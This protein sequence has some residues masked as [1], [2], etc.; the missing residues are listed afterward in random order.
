MAT[1]GLAQAPLQWLRR[2]RTIFYRW[3]HFLLPGAVLLGVL[4]A[5][6]SGWWW[7]ETAQNKAFDAFQRLRPRPYEDTAV[8]VVDIDDES[9]RRLGQFPWPRTEL[10][11]LLKRLTDLGAAAV[12]FDIVF[13]EPDRTSPARV[14]RFLP[15]TPDLDSVKE[16]LASL[17]DHDVA[18]SRQLSR[19]PAVMGFALSTE[20]NEIYPE[21]KSVYSYGG[22]GPLAYL[23]DFSGAV[24]NLPVLEKA[25]SGVG[26]FSFVP[27]SDGV[28]R[29]APLILRRGKHLYPGL[30][31]EALRV[32][33]GSAGYAVKSAGASGEASFGAHTGIAKIKIGRFV[34]PTDGE[35]RV[36]VHFPSVEDAQKRVI[37]AWK[38]F[39]KGFTRKEAE[40]RIFFVG[41]SA[42]GLKDLRVTPLNPAAAGVEVHAGIAE[43][44]LLGHFLQR[45]DWADGAELLYM[46]LLGL[47]VAG[48]LPFVGAA[49]C[50]PLALAGI[51][52]AVGASWK[53]FTDHRYLLDPV[54]PAGAVLLVYMVSSLV[55]YLKSEAERRQVKGAFSRYMSPA[56]VEQLAK[57]PE[58]LK[59]G[60]ETREMTFHFCDIRGFTTISEQF[61]PTAL[62]QFI[63]QF[64]TPMTE[65]LLKH[66]GFIDKYMGDCIMAF[67]NAPL[68]DP[69]HARNACRA[70]LAMHERLAA[71]NE[72]WKAQAEASGRT[73]IPIHIGTGLNTGPCVVGNMGSEMRFDYSVL[74]DAVNLASRLE[75]QSK[76][77]GVNIVVGPGTREQAPEFAMLELDLIRVKGK[78]RPVN[79]YA[80][81]GGAELEASEVFRTLSELHGRMLS[82]YR[83]QKWD[84]ARALVKACR[85]ASDLS[86]GVLYDLYAHRILEYMDQPPGRDWDGVYTAKTK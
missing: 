85:A 77:Y 75:G 16:R 38:V 63:N 76:I 34:V 46:A 65:I 69:E 21:R 6:V 36:W 86:L 47:L 20:P 82:A 24:A 64:L 2:R 3:A 10:A 8:R 51:A 22:D 18:F 9:L 44:M 74:G 49:W 83:S 55:S 17:E 78:T 27:D 33:Q 68:P 5:R 84:E 31:A 19:S 42:P 12:A 80:L 4:T 52:V 43:Q 13:A 23:P 71:L 28:I 40:G 61:E 59:L 30:A 41:T 35:G 73:F 79:I 32:A 48:L 1:F 81:L 53:A 72:T 39:D 54:F 25:A 67:W 50:F 60:G 58:Q 66:Q 26:A 11:R 7:V 14:A 37:P 29:R 70:A 56:L 15:A 57:H 62:T 45:P